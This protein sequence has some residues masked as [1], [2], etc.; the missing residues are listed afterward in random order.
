MGSLSDAAAYSLYPTKNLGALGDAGIVVSDDS[1]LVDKVRAL[2]NYG[3][4]RRYQS[5]LRG[6]NSRLDEIQAAVLR[7]KLERLEQWNERRRALARQYRE[8]LADCPGLILPGATTGALPVWHQ[9]VVR[10]DR[11]D[12]VREQ[13]ACR[14]IET[15]VHYPTPP[16][17]SPAYATDYPDPL[18]VTEQIAASVISLPISPQLGAAACERVC[19]AVTASITA[20]GRGA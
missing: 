13:L 9:F 2:A 5:E 6:H 14:G 10:L 12:L 1:A 4:H 11:R 3:E 20:V 7:V 18:P 15:L 16:H 19:E 17:R 8:Y